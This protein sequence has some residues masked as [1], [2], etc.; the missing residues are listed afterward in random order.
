MLKY[1]YLAINVYLIF[2]YLLQL[3]AYRKVGKIL[4]IFVGYFGKIQ[5]VF[6]YIPGEN[7]PPKCR[8][9]KGVT[10]LKIVEVV[11]L[12]KK[13]IKI[14]T[15]TLLHRKIYLLTC[16]MAEIDCV[17]KQNLYITELKNKK[18][19]IRKSTHPCIVGV[20][21]FLKWSLLNFSIFSLRSSQIAWHQS[22]C[23]AVS[24]TCIGHNHSQLYSSWPKELQTRTKKHCKI[25]LSPWF[26]WSLIILSTTQRP[27]SN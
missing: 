9:R 8:P 25:Q 23:C 11:N 5:N 20:T 10:T 14:K 6:Y 3:S 17:F 24:K 18:L 21:A 26:L 13:I 4:S 7:T 16:I 22:Y 27:P 12:Q 2:C 1:L 19:T 15:K